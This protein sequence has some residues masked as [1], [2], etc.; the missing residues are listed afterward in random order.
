MLSGLMQP[1]MAAQLMGQAQQQQA[2][3][4]QLG[5]LQSAGIASGIAGGSTPTGQQILQAQQQ[6]Q[7]GLGGGQQSG[8]QQSGGQQSGMLGGQQAQ[9][10]QGMS[11][12]AGGCAVC[13]WR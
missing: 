2:Q 10:Q 6:G 9:A 13:S 5:G 7:L 4:Q 11:S 3:Q 8:G 12:M 1:G